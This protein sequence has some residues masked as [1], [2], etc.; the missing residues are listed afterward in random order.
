[1]SNSTSITIYMYWL[2]LTSSSQLVYLWL[3]VIQSVTTNNPIGGRA[4]SI[5]KAWLLGA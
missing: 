2:L 1:M 3:H 5:K 4:Q